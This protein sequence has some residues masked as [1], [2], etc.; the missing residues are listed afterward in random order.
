VR[1][2]TIDSNT[3]LGNRVEPITKQRNNYVDKQRGNKISKKKVVFKD[4]VIALKH[5]A[6]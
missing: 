4:I 3:M 1:F 2:Q 6:L 5:S